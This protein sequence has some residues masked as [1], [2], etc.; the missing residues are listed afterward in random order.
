MVFREVGCDGG[1]ELCPIAGFG[2][3]DV[4]GSGF[5]TKILVNLFSKLVPK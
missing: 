2:V 5:S 1:S 3:S 4:E